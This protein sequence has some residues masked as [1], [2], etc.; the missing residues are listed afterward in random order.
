MTEWEKVSGQKQKPGVNK[1][2]QLPTARGLA[3]IRDPETSDGKSQ[4]WSDEITFAQWGQRVVKW[5]L[6]KGYDIQAEEAFE[7]ASFLL[8]DS[9][10]I[11]YDMYKSET[12]PQD[13]NIH[14]FLYPLREKVISTISKH[15]L[16][17][18]YHGC[19]HAHRGE[20]GKPGTVNQYAQKLEEYHIRCLDEDGERMMRN[21]IKKM[22]FVNGLIPVLNEKVRQL[23]D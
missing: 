3:K 15:E 8:T 22:T 11:S 6:W 21:Q 20:P 16:Q 14:S 5:L 12:E 13:R 2:K 4:E 9:A 10:G 23:V 7:T 1:S 19:H 17:N 18:P